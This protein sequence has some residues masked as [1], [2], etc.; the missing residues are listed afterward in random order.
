MA[1]AL[2]P[3]WRYQATYDGAP[4]PGAKL[5]T[6]L[7][8]TNTPQAT[9]TTA[10]LNTQHSNP[11]EADATGLFPAIYLAPVTYRV[12]LTDADGTTIIPAQ[13]GVSDIGQILQATLA[14]WPA[15][16]TRCGVVTVY[17]PQTQN[18]VSVPVAPDGY[19]IDTTGTVTAGLQE[20]IDY[21][22]AHGYDLDILGGDEATGG[23]V[24]YN[25]GSNTIEWPTMQGKKI[26]AGAITL[27]GGSGAAPIMRFDSMMMCDIDFSGMQIGGNR[28]GDML[29]FEPRNPLPKDSPIAIIDSRFHLTTIAGPQAGSSACVR[30]KATQAGTGIADSR[31]SFEEINGCDVGILIDT[32]ASDADVAFLDITAPHIH[33]ANGSQPH[34]LVGNTSSANNARIRD[35]NWNIKAGPDAGGLG[36]RGFHTRATR[37]RGFVT[38]SGD[39]SY[40]IY[41][42]AE[43]R[44]ALLFLA[45][46]TGNIDAA[47]FDA[48][49]A[50]TN[51]VLCQRTPERV[52]AAAGTSPYVYPATQT[53]Y[54]RDQTVIITGGTVSSI[55]IG[56]GTTWDAIGVTSG[57]VF[58]PAGLFLRITHTGA[59]TVTTWVV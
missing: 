31:F 15:P 25:I 41:F 19:A 34:V 1:R 30:F 59:P 8:G 56:N 18:G 6:Y 3:V 47:T 9:Y 12:T 7:S 46:D 13:D 22:C 28:T 44:Q 50:K 20:A 42:E 43:A 45:G 16:T 27:G 14:Q 23:A 48:S 5:Y 55:E 4:L 38:I 57:A 40:D 29:V 10:T 53:L 17:P 36:K 54:A 33:T 26:R 21:A 2:L 24:G 35:I 32:P 51:R 11:V 39:G 49:T 52:S 58:K 37:D